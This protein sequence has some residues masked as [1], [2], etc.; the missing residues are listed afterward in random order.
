MVAKS[1][2]RC[3]GG[4]GFGFDSVGEES[5][6][7]SVMEASAGAGSLCDRFTLLL[8]CESMV[9][10]LD[11]AAEEEDEDELEDREDLEEAAAAAAA[12]RAA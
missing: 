11:W 6:A 10:G 7:C 5:V 3:T 4:E 9:D 2:W 12:A 1:T 8:G